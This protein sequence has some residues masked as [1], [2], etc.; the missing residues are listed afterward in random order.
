MVHTKCGFFPESDD[1]D[2][3]GGDAKPPILSPDDFYESIGR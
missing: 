2:D 3:G 1:D